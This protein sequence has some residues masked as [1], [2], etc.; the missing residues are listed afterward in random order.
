MSVSSLPNN[1]R[2]YLDYSATTPIDPAV[3]DAMLPFLGDDFGNPSSVHADG[4]K[5]RRALDFARD[6]VSGA[7]GADNSELF[8]TSGGTEA[9]NTALMGVMLAARKTGRDHLITT[10]FEHHAV[11]DCAEWLSEN[12]GFKVSFVPVDSNGLLDP[13]LLAEYVTDKTALV[14]VMHANN[15]IGTIQ[16]IKELAEVAHRRGAYF[17]TDAVQTFGQLP[18]DVNALEVDLL[19]LSSHKI[20]GPKGIGALYIRQG[21]QIASLL[22]GGKQEREKRPGTENAAGIVGFGKAAELL[23]EWRDTEAVRI[24]TLRDIFIAMTRAH[25][26]GV[27]LNGHPTKR[28]ANNAHFSFPNAD[29]ETLLVALDRRGV[30]ASSGSA[31]SS[32]SIEPSH[33]LKAIGVPRELAQASVRFTLGR[34]TTEADLREVINALVAILH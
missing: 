21:T 11:L 29:G 4:Q 14:S 8:F 23:P 26:P 6:K 16:P 15:E 20:Y 27:K 5:V 18:L 30:S 10:T 13:E 28:L 9:D 32:G 34:K 1:R 25:F 2:I 19:T 7:I 17:H 22:H 33:V 24:S 12:F 3:R 31:C